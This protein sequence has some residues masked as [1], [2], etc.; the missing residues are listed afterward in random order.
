MKS[1]K[2]LSLGILIGFALSLSLS[3]ATGP[4]PVSFDGKWFFYEPA[5]NEEP[6]ACLPKDDV[7]KL[8][9]ILITCRGG[10]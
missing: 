5:P 1:I 2:H 10:K 8:R 7:K 4:D 3:C 9:E 6:F